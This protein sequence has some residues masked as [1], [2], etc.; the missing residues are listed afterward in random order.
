[1]GEGGEGRGGEGRGGVHFILNYENGM[2]LLEFN[3]FAHKSRIYS[4]AH[5]SRITLILINFKFDMM[6]L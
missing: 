6:F 5:R 1:M 2:K 3:S 4:I